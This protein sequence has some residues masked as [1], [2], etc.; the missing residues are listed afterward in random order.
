ML[1]ATAHGV[2]TGE[3]ARRIGISPATASHHATIL[4]EAGLVASERQGNQVLHQLSP[5]GADLLEADLTD[6]DL[7]RAT[8]QGADLRRTILKGAN[9]SGAYILQE[10]GLSGAV[11]DKGTQWP[12]GFRA[13]QRGAVLASPFALRELP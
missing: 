10:T 2:T 6:A 11:Y 13:D 4:R 7:S 3:L 12:A 5:A 8:M 9:L 1:I